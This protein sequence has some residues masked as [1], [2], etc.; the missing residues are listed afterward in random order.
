MGSAVRI[1]IF[2]GS[3]VYLFPSFRVTACSRIRECG[4]VV[5]VPSWGFGSGR[6]RR[7]DSEADSPADLSTP[8]IDRGSH[9]FEAQRMGRFVRRF[10]MRCPGAENLQTG[11]IV[12]TAW[13]TAA[14][15]SK[16]SRSIASVPDV[17]GATTKLPPQR[18]DIT[19]AL[20]A[21]KTVVG[22]MNLPG[23]LQFAGPFATPNKY[24]PPYIICLKSSS[25]TR[26]TVALFFKGDTYVSA[27]TATAADR[28]DSAPYQGCR[29]RPLDAVVRPQML[30]AIKA[31][32]N[33]WLA[34]VEAAPRAVGSARFRHSTSL[35]QVVRSLRHR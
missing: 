8:A 22:Q 16:R 9:L 1:A 5:S 28:C 14:L 32:T 3:T 19:K 31:G 18:P 23:P 29:T 2:V 20:P 25:E 4:L 15:A 17:R 34:I 13:S 12:T 35:R 30:T 33:R 7:D 26:F 21:I 10:D 11:L 6:E 27:R 24:D